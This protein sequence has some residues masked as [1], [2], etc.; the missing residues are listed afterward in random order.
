M[1][2]YLKIHYL[3]RFQS[4]GKKFKL[5][6][7]VKSG[8]FLLSTWERRRD[9]EGRSGGHGGQ[10]R[11]SCHSWWRRGCVTVSDG[12]GDTHGGVDS[13]DSGR[14]G[15]G[16]SC[17][18]SFLTLKI[19]AVSAIAIWGHLKGI[20]ISHYCNTS[21]LRGSPWWPGSGRSCWEPVSRTP[22]LALVEVSLHV[23]SPW[24]DFAAAWAP[25]CPP[26]DVT[27][28]L[29]GAGVLENFTA[30]VTAVTAHR[31]GRQVVTWG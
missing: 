31:V 29:E 10:N 27:V 22:V 30:L 7:W 16:S 23:P 12:C 3:I 9:D 8:F 11:W 18:P 14:G 15:C 19:H 26:V 25:V 28:V 5:S 13:V 17:G 4:F 20:T 21:Y 1:H 24:E 2:A 6:H